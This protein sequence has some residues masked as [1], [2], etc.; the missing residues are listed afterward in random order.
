M[1]PTSICPLH[2]MEPAFCEKFKRQRSMVARFETLL[3]K[4]RV[5]ASRL[6]NDDFKQWVQSELDGYREGVDVPEYR[7][8]RCPSYGYF[9]GPFGRQLKNAPIPESYI[10][11]DLRKQ[12][13][14][15]Q[16][17][18]GV[19]ELADLVRDCKSGVLTMNWPS[20]AYPLSATRFM[21]A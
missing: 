16:L 9:S 3:R 11:K 20:D 13:S 2:D 21:R 8:L 6:Q 4:C 5:L 7:R 19:S 14:E 1:L 15:V 17:R 18:G 10:P 12:L